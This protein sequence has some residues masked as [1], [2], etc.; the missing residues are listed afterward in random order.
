MDG[1]L[2]LYKPSGMTSHDVVRRIRRITGTRRVGHAGTLDPMATGVLPVLV[3]SACAAQDYLTAHDKSYIAGV[4]FGV[5]TDTGDMTGEVMKVSEIL[6]SEEEVK[7]T[8][9]RFVGTL[10]QTPPMYSAVKV[11]GKK[12]YEL[13]R[14]GKTVE[15]KSRAVTVYRAD[16]LEKVSE[17]DYCMRFDVSKGTYIRTLAEDIGNALGCGAAL[18]SLERTRCGAFDISDAVTL[19]TLTERHGSGGATLVASL[20]TPVETAF[21]DLPEVR[22]SPFYARLCKNGSE[23]YLDRANI[24]ESVFECGDI[25][26]LYDDAG[27]FFA[28]GKLDRYEQGLA[29]KAATRFDTTRG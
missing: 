16:I 14:E 7:S 29:V 20:L 19:E 12:L 17:R 15:R 1:I 22:L 9:S 11:G 25:C 23:I 24:P 18:Y 10:E 2:N 3:G 5:V 21:S 8:V 26:R 6:P 13:A 27:V 4:R 28:I